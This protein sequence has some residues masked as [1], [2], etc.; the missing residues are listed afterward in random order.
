MRGKKN[1]E[2]HTNTYAEKLRT[3]NQNF[4]ASC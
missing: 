4:K 2:Y 1:D 3:G